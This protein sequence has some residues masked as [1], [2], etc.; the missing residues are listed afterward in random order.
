MLSCC[1]APV[2]DPNQ[3]SSAV[4][5][6]SSYE[7]Q[8]SDH[9]HALAFALT[10]AAAR[11]IEE[12]LFRMSNRRAWILSAIA[13]TRSQPILLAIEKRRTRG[14]RRPA[15]A[16]RV[17]H[18]RPAARRG[19]SWRFFL[20]FTVALCLERRRRFRQVN[21]PS[22][23]GAVACGLTAPLPPPAIWPTCCRSRVAPPGIFPAAARPDS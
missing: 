5:D 11:A 14:R 9:S 17:G 10:V 21:A 15:C 2:F 8:V 23:T 3:N 13:P 1:G 16:R 18:Q 6:V 7:P 12:R 22:G 20:P 19:L 4:V